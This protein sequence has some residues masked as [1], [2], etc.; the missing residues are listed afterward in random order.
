[1]TIDSSHATTAA[2]MITRASDP[3]IGTSWEF[4]AVP[5]RTTSSGTTPI[6]RTPSARTR[7]GRV[8]PAM[9]PASRSGSWRRIDAI[10][11]LITERARRNDI[12]RST[13]RI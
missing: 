9:S 7:M 2:Q 1:M 12:L 6:A 3:M 13:A 4:S 11:A 8:K 10:S 5:L